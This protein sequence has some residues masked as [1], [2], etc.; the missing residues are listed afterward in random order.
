MSNEKDAKQK[1]LQ[2][3]GN[4]VDLDNALREKYKIGE[5]FRFIRDRLRALQAR[6]EENLQVA[7]EEASA[8]DKVVGEDEVIVYVYL[9]NAQGLVLQSWQKLL[10][11]SVFY[12]FSVNRPIYAEKAHIETFVRNKPNKPQH[13]FLSIIIKKSAVI[14]IPGIELKDASGHILVKVKE[15]SLDFDRMISFTHLEEEY[16]LNADGSLIKKPV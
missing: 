9:F 13:G 11:P 1:L 14:T 15:G 16:V 4:A 12:E 3:I 2:L 8:S 6:V 10:S 5:K 7:Q